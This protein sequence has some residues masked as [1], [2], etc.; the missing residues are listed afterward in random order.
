[1]DEPFAALDAQTR[2]DAQQIFLETWSR[3]R[4]TVVF[5]THD[6]DEAILLGDRVI[7]MYAGRAVDEVAIDMPRPRDPLTL[8]EEARYRPLH[9]RL[10]HSLTTGEPAPHEEVAPAES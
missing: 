4:K 6:L 2:I 5:V 7:V 1:M 8:T 10:V 3:S 9:H